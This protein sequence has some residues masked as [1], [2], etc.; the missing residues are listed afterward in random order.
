MLNYI[1][2]AFATNMVSST[3]GFLATAAV[4]IPEPATVLLLIFGAVMLRK[5]EKK[6]SVK[7]RNVEQNKDWRII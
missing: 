3:V 7:K 6:F 1:D 5:K 2:Y 4:P